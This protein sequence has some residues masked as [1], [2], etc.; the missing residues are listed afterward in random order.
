MHEVP[1]IDHFI[2]FL[3]EITKQKIVVVG[4]ISIENYQEENVLSQ[5][6]TQQGSCFQ[7]YSFGSQQEFQCSKNFCKFI[8]ETVE[9][10][11]SP[12]KIPT[13]FQ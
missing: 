9:T 2:E 11:T 13:I 3:H 4:E 12:L 1:T 5:I 8:S 6:R 7:F 10:N